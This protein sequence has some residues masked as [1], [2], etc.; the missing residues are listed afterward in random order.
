MHEFVV[1]LQIKETSYVVQTSCVAAVSHVV[2]C[3][4]RVH[5]L[6]RHVALANASR[7]MTNKTIDIASQ[8]YYSTQKN[9]CSEI[10]IYAI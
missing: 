1:V 7:K 3:E 4:L 6:S 9:V 5:P 8:F 2:H 10:T